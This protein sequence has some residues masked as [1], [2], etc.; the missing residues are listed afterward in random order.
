MSEE[1][2]RPQEERR[3]GNGA[4]LARQRPKANSG[5]RLNLVVEDGNAL[6]QDAAEPAGGLRGPDVRAETRIQAT[7][8]AGSQAPSSRRRIA[9]RS[10]GITSGKSC[11][12]AA[13]GAIRRRAS[14]R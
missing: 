13:T 9:P 10:A 11:R 8:E 4:F 5:A 12:A 6:I 14:N 1:L 7:V 2:S 3:A